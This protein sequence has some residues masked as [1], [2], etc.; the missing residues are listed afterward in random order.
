MT[1]VFL[2]LAFECSS[3]EGPIQAAVVCSGKGLWDTEPGT[4]AATKIACP[5]CAQQNQ[6]LFETS[7][8]IRSVRPLSCRRMLPEP[9]L[10]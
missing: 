7:G 9:S 3:C 2:T 10:N 5:H 6:V 4:V 8:E 1:Q